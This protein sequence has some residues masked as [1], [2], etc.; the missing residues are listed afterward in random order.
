MGNVC[1]N[2]KNIA[3]CIYMR[4]FLVNIYQTL[5]DTY[6]LNRL[7]SK[8]GFAQLSKDPPLAIPISIC[9]F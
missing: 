8:N 9:L 3:T 6:K 7:V 4:P 5:D 2:G 1:A